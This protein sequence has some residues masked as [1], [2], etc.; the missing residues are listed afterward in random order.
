MIAIEALPVPDD[1][2]GA[3]R[4]V[5]IE[6]ECGGLTEDAVA[7]IL[8]DTLGGRMERTADFE[9]AVRDTE[10]GDIEVLLDTAFRDKAAGEVARAGLDLSRYVV[11][12][13]FVT[14]PIE[15]ARIPRVDAAAR[16]LAE[17]GA[18]GTQ[19]GLVLG[20]GLHL[21]VALHGDRIADMLPVLT[22]FAL[23]E[24]WMRDRIGIDTSRRALPFVATYPTALLDR[25]CTL[26]VDWTPELLLQT[27]LATAPSRNHALD[28][29]PILKM[30]DPDRVVEA[31]PQMGHKSGRYAWH[32]RLPDC[33]IDQP[34]WS[35]SREWNRWCAVERVAAD[36]LLVDRLKEKWRAYRARPL[37]VPGLWAATSAEILDDAVVMP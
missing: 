25:L 32:Y 24:D 20:F 17:A 10:I 7:Q 15:P 5:G 12:V 31:V 1:Q 19:D 30:I 37:P 3:P 6:I 34:D 27:Y 16:A 8:C 18:T 21:N 33:R 9:Y 14:E 13:E 29:L 28:M 2:T 11:P 36:A 4:R 22:A 26:G 35:V 23:I